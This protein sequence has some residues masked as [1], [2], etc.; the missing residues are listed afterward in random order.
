MVDH[1][2]CA[3]IVGT[4]SDIAVG[5]AALVA[6]YIA[7]RGLKTWREQLSGT[8]EYELARRVLRALYKHRDAINAVRY[9]FM[10]VEEMP[11]PDNTEE[12]SR[13]KVRYHGIAKA[14]QGRWDLVVAANR[15]LAPEL[16]EAEVLWGGDL[17]TRF[18]SIEKL[19]HELF[20][21]VR[22]HVQ[23]HNPDL[24]EK[25]REAIERIISKRRDILFSNLDDTDD[26]FRV[27]YTAAVREIE[28]YLR[29]HLRRE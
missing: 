25:R 17:K 29:P 24:N 28:D 27:E 21:A 7:W 22:H 15:E 5:F 16:L 9:S 2:G 3:E 20:V 10:S 4:L 14:Y 1:Q 23:V 13:E 12:M 6:T 11:E 8:T 26:A 19:E 18:G